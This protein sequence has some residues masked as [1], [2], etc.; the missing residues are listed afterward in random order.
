MPSAPQ[1][2]QTAAQQRR[3]KGQKSPQVELR[4]K[5]YRKKPWRDQ[6]ARI[7][8]RDGMQCQICWKTITKKG[9]AHCD[10]IEEITLPEEVLCEDDELQTTCASCHSRKTRRAMRGR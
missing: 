8:A 2:F 5:E 7:L 6:R 9:D 4:C 3:K 10:H 1:R